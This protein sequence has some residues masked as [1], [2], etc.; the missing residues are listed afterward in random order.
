MTFRIC[1]D[2]YIL[3]QASSVPIS[4]PTGRKNP[5]SVIV[6]DVIVQV[7]ATNVLSCHLPE[8]ADWQATLQ[9]IKLFH[10]NRICCSCG[11]GAL[12]KRSLTFSQQGC[13]ET[14]QDVSFIS[15]SQV[16]RGPD[17]TSNSF[18]NGCLA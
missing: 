10:T 9:V 12:E 4:P 2:M 3:G 17:L 13:D 8:E 16:S 15:L 11:C 18:V 5:A 14:C 6:A 7:V 1:A